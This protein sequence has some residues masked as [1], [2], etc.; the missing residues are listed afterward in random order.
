M[1]LAIAKFMPKMRFAKSGMIFDIAKYM[2]KIKFYL[3][4]ILQ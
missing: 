2:P 4:Y 1:I 3:A